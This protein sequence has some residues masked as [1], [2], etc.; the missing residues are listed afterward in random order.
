MEDVVTLG[1]FEDGNK[2]QDKLRWQY[3]LVKY[4]FDKAEGELN[5]IGKVLR[6][7]RRYY[8]SREKTINCLSKRLFS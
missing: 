5:P 3:G 2:Q 1:V 8:A 4:S 6:T 7:S